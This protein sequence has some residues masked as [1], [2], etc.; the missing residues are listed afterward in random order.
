MRIRVFLRSAGEGVEAK[1]KRKVLRGFHKGLLAEGEDT[2]L[3]S[4][5]GYERCDVAVV[6]GGRPSAKRAATRSV[7]DEIFGR[8]EGVFV[9]IETPLFG[10]SVYRR[11]PIAA[12][13]R[14]LLR[15]GRNR[16]SDEYGY[17]RVG[18]NGFLQ[19]DA[20]FNNAGSPPDRWARISEEL[21][22]RLKPYRSDGRHVLIVGQN[23]GD[24]SLRGADIFAWMHR[25]AVAARG[26]TDRPIIVRPHPVTPQLMM[27]EFDT[28][29][30]A[31][32][33][34]VI[35]YPPIRPV[36]AVLEDCWVLLAYSSSAS[37]DALI[38]GIPCITSSPANMAWPVSDHE[39]ERIEQPTLFPR[40]QWLSDLA[41]A[42]WSPEEMRSGVTWRQ[43]RSAVLRALLAA[44]PTPT[45]DVALS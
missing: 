8:H 10:R 17:Y 37:I 3:V 12:Y 36:R 15:L 31:M 25:T 22:L 23:P 1:R 30:S 28:R 2:Q 35:D 34:I 4:G 33:G 14:K 42:Q 38:E 39:L 20:D 44:S 27:R 7:R 16:Y 45:E 13:A 11:A 32:K 24:A 21:G 19:D 6:L 40:E 5:R 18:V 41:Y 43:L 9:F 29:F 26:L